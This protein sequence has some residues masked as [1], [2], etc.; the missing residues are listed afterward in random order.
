MCKALL[1]TKKEINLQGDLKN[2]IKFLMPYVLNKQK[3]PW[4]HK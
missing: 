2:A 1:Q 3:K 4:K